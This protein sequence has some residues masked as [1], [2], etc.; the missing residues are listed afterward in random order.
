[1][2][3]AT[4]GSEGTQIGPVFSEDS[5]AKPVVAM[6]VG[7]VYVAEIF[8]GGCLLDPGD[9]VFGLRDRYGC[10]NKNGLCVSVD[11]GAGGWR[12]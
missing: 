5:D 6:A 8:T 7:D 9:E 4:G 11:K 10:V 3:D 2:F 12:E 1:V